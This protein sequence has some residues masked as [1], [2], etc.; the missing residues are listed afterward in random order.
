ML[1]RPIT[2]ALCAAAG[3]VF[4]ALVMFRGITPIWLFNQGE[5]GLWIDDAVRV[6]HGEVMYRDFFEFL[7][8]GVVYVNALLIAVLGS[9]AASAMLIPLLVGTA[10]TVL[11]GHLSSKLLRGSWQIAPPLF[12]AVVVYP[13]YTLGN[14]KWLTWFFALAAIDLVVTGVVTSSVTARR[15]LL[16]GVLIGAAAMCTQD[17]GAAL[18]LGMLIAIWRRTGVRGRLSFLTGTLI[19]PLAAL[20]YFTSKAGFATMWYDLIVFPLTR[21]GNV[22]GGFSLGEPASVLHVPRIVLL[23]AASLV[24]CAAAIVAI[25]RRNLN[26]WAF[27]V[28][29]GLA[30]VIFGSAVRAVEPVQMAV[31]CSLLLIVAVKAIEE[32]PPRV[33]KVIAAAFAIGI[34]YVGGALVASRQLRPRPLVHTRAGDIRLM[35][36]CPEIEWLQA[37]AAP[38]EAVF[39]FPDEGGLLFLTHTRNATTYPSLQDMRFS[40]N[41]QIDDA[42]AQLDR[43]RPRIGIFDPKRLFSGSE[44]QASSLAPLYRFIDARYDMIEGKYFVLRARH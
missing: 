10:I 38:G 26:V 34:I 11:M 14:H 40:T 17:M 2:L 13:S 24:G 7:A 16:A 32:L 28:Y 22:N 18:A 42:I 19:V 43:Q 8:P 4:F 6:L 21:Y 30:V 44:P 20:L 9:S 27:I 35:E 3:M 15:A 37:H 25:V 5:S 39:L 23:W 41:S 1:S 12:F 33:A 31:R 29:P 36:P